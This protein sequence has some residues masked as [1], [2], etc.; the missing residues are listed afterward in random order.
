MVG[1]DQMD[2]TRQ[3]VENRVD[4]FVELVS[5]LF[6]V[7]GWRGRAESEIGEFGFMLFYI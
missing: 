1:I 3:R 6:A 4:L 5:R 7:L 2:F